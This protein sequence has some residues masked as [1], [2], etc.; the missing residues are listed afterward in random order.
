[1][2]SR[3]GAPR[4][5][6]ERSAGVDHN[7]TGIGFGWKVHEAVQS[8]V[9]NVDFKASV[10]LLVE[11]AV[12][13]GAGKSL[14]TRKGELHSAVG[15]HLATAITA[16]S[17]LGLAV[18]CALWVVFPRLERPR[19]DRLSGVGLIYFGHLRNR[20]VEEIAA[21]LSAMTPEAERLQLASQMRITSRIAWRK[22]SWLQRSL[23]LFALGAV[24]LVV[25][26]VA[27]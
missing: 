22:H 18:G 19:T 25:A 8:W 12:T 6:S 1:M 17:L 14:L 26:L 24:L 10:V 4:R 9:A 15:L 7:T 5:S 13:G 20:S 23:I 21:E 27:F 2:W 11:I 16:G 3:R